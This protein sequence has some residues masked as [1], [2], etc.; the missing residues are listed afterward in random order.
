MADLQEM[1]LFPLG[2]VLF[3]GMVLPL[4]IF[5]PRYRTMMN[6]CIQEGE[7]FGVVLIEKGHEVGGVAEPFAVG[8]VARI[9]H[10]QPFSDGRM[11][12]QS[13][14]Y[15]RIRVHEFLA[16]KPYPAGL[17]EEYPIPQGHPE[18]V[19]ALVESFAPEL[20]VYLD[21]LMEATDTDLTIDEMPEDG[22]ALALFAA[23]TLPLPMLDK[24]NILEQDDIVAM[25]RLEQSMLRREMMLLRH[26]INRGGPPE[27]PGFSSN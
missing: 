26:M 14:G 2:T 8:T 21:L 7:P 12:I 16:D 10:V 19:E 13:V 23:I 27:T 17:V 20:K 6:E 9:T 1:R 5:E 18:E 22:M 4:H 24:Q 11:N 3:P 25:L 15:Q